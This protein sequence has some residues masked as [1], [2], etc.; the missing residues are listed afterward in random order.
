[1]FQILAAS[2]RATNNI[3]RSEGKIK[4]RTDIP[5]MLNGS[6]GFCIGKNR[7]L[8][9]GIIIGKNARNQ[10]SADSSD[11]AHNNPPPVHFQN[12]STRTRCVQVFC[13]A[14]RKAIQS[15]LS[16]QGASAASSAWSKL[17]AS[18]RGKRSERAC[19]M[20]D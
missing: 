20:P 13:D 8:C 18:S 14:A 2:H 1:T 19:P 3:C 9:V 11:N 12:C 15:H 7:F 10:G 4:H 16:C 6:H 5:A 17:S